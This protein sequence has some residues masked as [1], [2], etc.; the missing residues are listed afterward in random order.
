MKKVIYYYYDHKKVEWRTAT[1]EMSWFKYIWLR[2]KGLNEQDILD[3][4]GGFGGE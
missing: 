2:I 1:K 3:L 4:K